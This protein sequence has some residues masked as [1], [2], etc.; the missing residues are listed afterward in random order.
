MSKGFFCA[1]CATLFVRLLSYDGLLAFFSQTHFPEDKPY[2]SYELF[3]FVFI[4]MWFVSIEAFRKDADLMILCSGLFFAFVSVAFI[5]LV[6]LIANLRSRYRILNE[7]CVVIE[8]F[9]VA[10]RL[11]T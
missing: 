9:V 6:G 10:T 1:V 7:R 3:P 2:Q 11:P 8:I 5:K 4:G